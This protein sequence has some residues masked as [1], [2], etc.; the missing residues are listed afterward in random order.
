MGRVG[1]EYQGGL[2]AVVR[3]VLEGEGGFDPRFDPGI[4][5]TGC[6]GLDG[7][8][9]QGVCGVGFVFIFGLEGVIY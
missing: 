3:V 9:G 6:V 8:L 4:I 1:G 7:G 2:V 5:K